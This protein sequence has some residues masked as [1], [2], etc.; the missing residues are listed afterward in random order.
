[1]IVNPNRPQ[2]EIVAFSAANREA[3]K[4]RVKDFFDSV[5]TDFE[6]IQ[7]QARLAQSQFSA[8]DA[9]R[10]LMVLEPDTSPAA[11]KEKA[12]H[13]LD[14]TAAIDGTEKNIYF[15][16]NRTY[17]KI[18]FVFPGQGSQYVRMG[19]DLVRCCRGADEIL[20][21]ADAAFDQNA[22]L[23]A[24]IFP[25]PADSKDELKSQEDRLRQTEMAQ[26]AIGAISLVMRGCLSNF[27]VSP[28]AVCGHSYGE[29]TALHAAGRISRE[30]FFRLSVA[31]GRYMAKAGEQQ[32]EAGTMMAVKAP[33]DE[34]P[35]LIADYGLDIILANRNSPDQGVLSGPTPDIEKMHGVLKENHIRAIRL[36]V[37]AAFHSRLV[38]SAARPFQHTLQTID[39]LASDIPVYSN[40]TGRPYPTDDEAAK[41]LLGRHLTNP[42]H[43]I[44]DIETMCADVVDMFIEVG[45]KTV[46][47]GLIRS[48]LKDRDHAAIA[49]DASSG[50]KPG[51][52]DLANTL[53]QLAASGYPVDLNRWPPQLAAGAPQ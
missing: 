2:T 46:L 25:N 30:D 8:S 32:G 11:V 21:Q 31:R 52:R 48:I 43:F 22:R 41:Q 1:M 17:R 6:S 24:I 36:P 38:E 14:H 20:K 9:C 37:A 15:G 35:K 49:L 44:D 33:I 18:G 47:T 34:I 7:K 19:A 4:K 27:S 13:H 3:V 53:C 23:S 51:I 5:S 45:P 29:L 39:F 28:D 50:K 16:E 42:I 12:L 10:L 40:T 26:P